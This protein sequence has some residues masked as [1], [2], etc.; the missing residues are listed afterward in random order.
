[1]SARDKHDNI[2]RLADPPVGPAR[3]SFGD[4]WREDDG[5]PGRDG[6]LLAADIEMVAAWYAT[7]LQS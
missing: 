6:E 5:R 3:R 7:T 1:M 4:A 2:E